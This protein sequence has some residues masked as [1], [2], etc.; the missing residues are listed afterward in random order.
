MQYR[1]FFSFYRGASAVL[2]VFDITN[3]NSFKNI[4][5]WYDDAKRLADVHA[6]MM[7]VGNKKDKSRQRIISLVEATE[8]ASNV[9]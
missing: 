7:L 6:V 9:F 3:R 2:I 1:F 8:Y 5:K 4:E